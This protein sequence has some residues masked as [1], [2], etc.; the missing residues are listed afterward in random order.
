MAGT[1]VRNG[2]DVAR[3][4]QGSNNPLVI[5]FDEDVTVPKLSVTLWNSAKLLKAWDENTIDRDGN[6]IICAL[7]EDETSAFP[8]SNVT[9]EI[10]GLDDDGFTVFWE[11]FTIN[12][13]ARKDKVIKLTGGD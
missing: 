11:K 9:I 5:E 8:A 10:K 13:E 4:L 6:R 3:I 12:V 7:S 2:D 1:V